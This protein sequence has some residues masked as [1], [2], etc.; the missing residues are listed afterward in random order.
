MYMSRFPW[1]RFS[2]T[3]R[4]ATVIIYDGHWICGTS[5]G[6]SCFFF[7]KLASNMYKNTKRILRG[8]SY[9]YYASFLS[10]LRKFKRF[11][12]SENSLRNYM[13]FSI[14]PF[15]TLLFAI[16]ILKFQFFFLLYNALAI[17]HNARLARSCF[18]NRLQFQSNRMHISFRTYVYAA[19]ISFECK[20]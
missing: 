5:L 17:M 8:I 13:L 1:N 7:F 16:I 19:P 15:S 18:G 9:Y 10:I 6:T 14:H 3:V 20:N 4:R 11:S 12:F 2:H